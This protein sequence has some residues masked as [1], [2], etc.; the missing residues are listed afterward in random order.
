MKK[1]WILILLCLFAM[2]SLSACNNNNEE[3]DDLTNLPEDSVTE[4]IVSE[5]G[6]IKV[7]ATFDA[8]KEFVQAV[9]KDKVEISTIKTLK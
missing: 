3:S 2:M 6:K 5:E 7:S 9:G 1:N 8:M 4:E